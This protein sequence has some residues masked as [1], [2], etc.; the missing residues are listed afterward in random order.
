MITAYG[1]VENA[2][3]AIQAGAAISSKPWDNEKLLADVR[4]AVAATGPRRKCAKARP[5]TATTSKT[6]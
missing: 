2:V 5:E 4:A 1:T 6:L 3:K